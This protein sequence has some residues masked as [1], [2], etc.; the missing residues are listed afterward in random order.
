MTNTVLLRD[1]I[2]K[3]GYKLS[4]IADSIHLS[5]YGLQRKIENVSEFKTSEVDGLCKLLHIDSLDE[6]ER[7]FFAQKDDLKS[8]SEKETA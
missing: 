7:V 3:S 8:P 1:W 2:K 6:K 4:F 5:T